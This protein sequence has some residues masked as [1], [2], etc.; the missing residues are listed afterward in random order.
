[1]DILQA[2]QEYEKW[3]A[4]RIQTLPRDLETKHAAMKESPFA[5]LRATFYR[6]VQVW[7]ETC[8]SLEGAPEVLA[9]GDLH[10]EN[11]GTWRDAEGRLVWGI[12]DFDEAYSMPY[13]M[14][15]VRVA[16]SALLAIDEGHLNLSPREGCDSLLQGYQDGLKDGRPW[17]LEEHHGFL[18]TLAL[19]E[20]RDPVKFWAKL[21]ALP[22]PQIKVPST[23]A[24]ILID[25]LPDRSLPFTL[26]G[27][28]AGLGSLGRIRVVALAEWNGGLVAREAKAVA[29]SAYWWAMGAKGQPRIWAGEIQDRAVRQKDPCWR[30]YPAWTVRRLSAHCGKIEVASLPKKKDEE[31]LLQAMGFETANIHQ[32]SPKA[33][34]AVRKDL[35]KRFRKWLFHA[36]RDM[37]DA[38]T[39]DFDQ[40]RKR[41]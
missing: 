13:T 4:G 9:V 38:V 41:A 21:Q 40:F 29:P 23:L 16:A 24:R 7:K 1:M 26:K 20:A 28:V 37:A 12:N 2:T 8:P 6:W 15:L 30:L 10:I 18:R 33:V 5:F 22:K 11:F 3:L 17:V 34:P 19:S 14:D 35:A 25:S 31:K 39:R 32:G 27:R 36:A